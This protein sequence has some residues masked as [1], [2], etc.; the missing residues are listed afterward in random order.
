MR[1]LCTLSIVPQELVSHQFI[2]EELLEVIKFVEGLS[3]QSHGIASSSCGSG[4]IAAYRLETVTSAGDNAGC[5]VVDHI[6]RP[7]TDRSCILNA[8]LLMRCACSLVA[9]LLVLAP[10]DVI[11]L[12]TLGVSGGGCC[13]NVRLLV[14][15]TS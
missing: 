13:G 4:W 15:L 5:A 1:C 12:L 6:T 3:L 10:P 14:F 2:S 11:P 7:G 8:L 9:A